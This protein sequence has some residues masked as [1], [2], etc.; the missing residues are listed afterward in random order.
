MDS[1]LYC[2]AALNRNVR[3]ST[4]TRQ[5]FLVLPCARVANDCTHPLLSFVPS[6]SSCY[7]LRNPPLSSHPPASIPPPTSPRSSPKA[8][9][10]HIEPPAID[11]LPAT[12]KKQPSPAPAHRQQKTDQDP[13][14]KPLLAQYHDHEPA[15]HAAARPAAS[16]N[17]AITRPCRAPNAAPTP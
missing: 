5:L 10:D 1:P 7:H 3:I 13:R 6:P 2:P 4:A 14:A 8:A 11:R 9:L 16:A 15:A 17:T 12:L